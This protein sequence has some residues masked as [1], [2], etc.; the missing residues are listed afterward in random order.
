MGEVMPGKSSYSWLTLE[1]LEVRR[2]LAGDGAA[3]W[4]DAGALDAR[5]L[6]PGATVDAQ[7]G[8]TFDFAR[9]AMEATLPRGTRAGAREVLLPTPDGG[10]ARF[11][12]RQTSLL[13]PH[14]AADNSDVHTYRAVGIDDP[15]AVVQFDLTVNG[16]HATVSS[17]TGWWV[18]SPVTEYAPDIRAGAGTYASYHLDELMLSAHDLICEVVHDG[19]H[20]HDELPGAGGP[21]ATTG[22]I[23][24]QMRIAVAG[25]GEWTIEAGGTQASGFATIV[26]AV[27]A[28]DLLYTL[29]HGVGFTLVSGQNIVYTN[30]A[31]DPYNNSSASQML[32][33]NQSNLDAVIG[34]ANYDIGHVFTRSGGGVASLGVVGQTGSKA[35][36][37]SGN[38]PTGS[39]FQPTFWHEMGH[40]FG[41]DHTWNHSNAEYS[42]QRAPLSA[43]EPGPGSTIM[44]YGGFSFFPG[45]FVPMRDPY[46]HARSQEQVS[47]YLLFD[48]WGMLAG[49][50]TQTGNLPPVVNAGVDRA[51]PARTPFELLGSGSDATALQYAWEQYDLGDEDPIGID[52]GNGPLFRSRMPSPNPLRPFP[53]LADILA[54]RS[55]P[56]ETLP[57]VARITDPLT[58][59]F[60]ARD[61]LGGVNSDDVNLTVIDTGAA[62]A[63]TSNNAPGTTWQAGS[64]QTITWNV[65]GTDAA[66][67][68]A[69]LVS[70]Y[71][72]YDNGV[73]VAP[74]LSGTANDGSATFTIPHDAPTTASARVKVKP[75]NN[76]FFDINN[77]PIRIDPD[78][79]L[80][81]ESFAFDFETRHAMV[82]RFGEP[83]DASTISLDDLLVQTLPGGP[84]IP[85]GHFTLSALPGNEQ[86]AFTYAPPAGAA[87]LPDG[88]YRATIPAG[89]VADLSGNLLAA[90]IVVE[91]FF[92]GGDAN[93]DR[94]VNL[95]DF[96]ILAANFG[97][98]ER[99]FSQADFTYDGVVNLD[100]FNVLA[101]RFGSVLA[102]A[103]SIS[104]SDDPDDTAEPPPLVS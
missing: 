29:E 63:I 13:A 78:T 76:V 104:G 40:Q 91:F 48:T 88:D 54:N 98:P 60:T 84:I 18:V 23:H 70:I 33:Q 75:D 45:N 41:A 81:V 103:A 38:S 96:N 10:L 9:S 101:Q 82:L 1:A 8:W 68:D 42:Q 19:D 55:D 39:S 71:L 80:E 26:T 2:L 59:R 67:F 37:V 15:S 14:V 92:L 21:D 34:N 57:Q 99:T 72:S 49:T 7:A 35:R 56:D 17:Q 5:S 52:D 50:Q 47:N 11:A 6:P 44:S 94:S 16:F 12:V 62:F 46:F 77:A 51:I 66:Q 36:G 20:D 102:P 27:N 85:S 3:Y 25:N 28:A 32:G 64:T 30:P 69:Q 65:A 43:Y 87:I 22:P 73:T 79:T 31:T 4:F 61:G 93:R 97:Q 53:E 24:Y 74:V 58:F 83:I 95:D 89:A 86:F 90:D 100:D